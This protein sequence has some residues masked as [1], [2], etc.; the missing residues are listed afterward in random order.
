[1]F[2][3]TN[4]S[5]SPSPSS[6]GLGC[7]LVF[8]EVLERRSGQGPHAAP[9]QGAVELGQDDKP[10][11]GAVHGILGPCVYVLAARAGSA[12]GTGDRREDVGGFGALGKRDPTGVGPDD[13]VTS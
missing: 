8:D 11:A 3:L 13:F 10:G 5:H 1:L 7:L 6:V 9:A 4:C 2:L 12:D